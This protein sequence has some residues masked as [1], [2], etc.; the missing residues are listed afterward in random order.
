MDNKPIKKDE[1]RVHKEDSDTD[2]KKRSGIKHWIPLILAVL[3]TI[4]PADLVPDV[5]PVAGW[6]EDALFLVV[7][8]LNVV[9]YSLSS[10]NDTLIGIVKL[11]KWGLL[12]LGAITIGIIVLIVVGIL[13]LF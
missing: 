13:N 2:K 11:I 6:F 7:G 1:V 3:Y 4:S 10:N 5:I 8:G 9:Q 12:I